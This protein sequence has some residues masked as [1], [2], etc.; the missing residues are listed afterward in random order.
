MIR[1]FESFWIFLGRNDGLLQEQKQVNRTTVIMFLIT[2]IHF[3]SAVTVYV[4]NLLVGNHLYL[5]DGVHEVIGF[6]FRTLYMVIYI[7]NPLCYMMMSSRFRERVRKLFCRLREWR[8]NV[9]QKTGHG[10]SI[11]GQFFFFS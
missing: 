9:H 2:L 8:K 11:S 6:T 4:G 7:T 1:L 5:P 10:E 3:S